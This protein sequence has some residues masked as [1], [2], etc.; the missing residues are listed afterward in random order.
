MVNISLLYFPDANQ[1][2]SLEGYRHDLKSHAYLFNTVEDGRVVHHKII[3]DWPQS[4]NYGLWYTEKSINGKNRVSK[5]KC[6]V[7][8]YVRESLRD[9]H[10]RKD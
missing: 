6:L 3:I 4:E 7:E 2:V 5:A 1:M 8:K 10:H 9:D